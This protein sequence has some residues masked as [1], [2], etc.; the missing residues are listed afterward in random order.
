MFYL[1]TGRWLKWPSLDDRQRQFIAGI[2]N[3]F[4]S[5]FVSRVDYAGAIYLYYISQQVNELD[6]WLS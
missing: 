2:F 1:L 3:Q 4:N 6:E 5:V